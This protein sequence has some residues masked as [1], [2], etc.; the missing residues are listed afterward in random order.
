MVERE[1]QKKFMGLR[2]LHYKLKINMV[3]DLGFGIMIIHH[4]KCRLDKTLS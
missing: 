2:K 1:V 3:E 4:S